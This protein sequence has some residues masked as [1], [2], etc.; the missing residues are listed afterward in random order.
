MILTL[1]REFR[2]VHPPA[3]LCKIC[4]TS[5]V[6]KDA[7]DAHTD[8]AMIKK[9]H[10]LFFKQQKK[11]ERR[12]HFVGNVFLGTQGRNLLARRVIF[13]PELA[14]SDDRI[15][16]AIEEKYRPSLSDPTG[17]RKTQMDMVC[18]TRCTLNVLYAP[19]NYTCFSFAFFDII[20]ILY[21]FYFKYFLCRVIILCLFCLV[22]LYLFYSA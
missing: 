14:M 3:F 18:N 10:R 13:S 8:K 7:Y 20:H 17:K 19:C 15:N 16:V 5:F 2:I 6:D 22:S 11:D 21:L 9:N 12:F 4:N 1:R